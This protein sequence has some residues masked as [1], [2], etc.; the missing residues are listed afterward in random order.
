MED[1]ESGSGLMIGLIIGGGVLV[2]VILLGVFGWGFFVFHDEVR[3][4]PVAAPPVMV[5]DPPAPEPPMPMEAVA[6]PV[7]VKKDK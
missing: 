4:A 3:V 6:P 7:E 1:Q 2:L 5:A